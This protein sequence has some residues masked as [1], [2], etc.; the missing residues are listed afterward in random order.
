MCTSVIYFN[1][2]RHKDIDVMG[3]LREIFP[4][5]VYKIEY[6]DQGEHWRQCLCPV[7]IRATIHRNNI[8]LPIWYRIQENA[9]YVN[10]VIELDTNMTFF[11]EEKECYKCEKHR[12]VMNDS[13]PFSCILECL[14]DGE[15]KV[16][17]L[18][19]GRAMCRFLV[20]RM[21]LS[22]YILENYRE[23]HNYGSFPRG[24]GDEGEIA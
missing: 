18:S 15:W 24:E 11:K 9:Y 2:G 22:E 1:E 10:F 8:K 4:Q 23:W 17:G 6:E 21:N 16:D 14:V 3:E 20:E 13:A 5:I 7:D 19:A 12:I